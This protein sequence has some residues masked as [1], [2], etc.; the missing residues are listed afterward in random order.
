MNDKC[1]EHPLADPDLLTPPCC[2]AAIV[3]CTIV[4]PPRFESSLCLLIR[5]DIIAEEINS[6]DCLPNSYP[7]LE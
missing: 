2:I 1:S 7:Y 6:N 4:R 5:N 3:I